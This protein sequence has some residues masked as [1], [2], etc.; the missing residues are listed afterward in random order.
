MPKLFLE[1]QFLWLVIIILAACLTGVSTLLIRLRLP[2]RREQPLRSRLLALVNQLASLI[3][4]CGQ[5]AGER[6]QSE[7]YS[8]ALFVLNEVRL[9][10]AIDDVQELVALAEVLAERLKR[11]IAELKQMRRRPK[12]TWEVK[13]DPPPKLVR[14]RQEGD[15]AQAPGAF[16]WLVHLV[17]RVQYTRDGVCILELQ[18][19]KGGGQLAFLLDRVGCSMFYDGTWALYLGKTNV[20]NQPGVQHPL[21]KGVNEIGIG[22][23]ILGA[24]WRTPDLHLKWMKVIGR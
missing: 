7:Q 19:P 9:T 11:W 4:E 2:V 17:T 20:I 14:Q 23:W 6:G 13:P 5:L 18:L 8:N 15:L 10:I 24:S 1:V 21:Q 12:R 22:P 16:D 3:D